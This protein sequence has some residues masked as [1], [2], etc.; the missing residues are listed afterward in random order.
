MLQQNNDTTHD[1]CLNGTANQGGSGV[2]R[3]SSMAFNTGSNT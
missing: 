3:R 2:Q 1:D